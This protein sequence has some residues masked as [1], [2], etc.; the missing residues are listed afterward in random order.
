MLGRNLSFID[1]I[2]IQTDNALRILGGHSVAD[3]AS[4]AEGHTESEL[5]NSQRR[6]ASRLMRVNHTGEICAQAGAS[7]GERPGGRVGQSP[8]RRAGDEAADGGDG[9]GKVSESS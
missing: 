4:P 3:R 5:T 7:G 6:L 2:L 1:K 8:R 9:Q